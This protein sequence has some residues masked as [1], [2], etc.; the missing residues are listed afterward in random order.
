MSRD[1]YDEI[2]KKFGE[3]IQLE[4]MEPDE[5]GYCCLAFNENII[6]HIQ[7]N[8]PNDSIMLFCEVGVIDEDKRSA[9]RDKM[10]AA[11]L[12]WQGTAGGTLGV[13]DDTGEVMMSFQ[14]ELSGLEFSKFQ[15]VLKEYVKN[16]ELWMNALAA[17]EKGE[18]LTEIDAL[19]H[20]SGG[21]S[22]AATGTDEGQSGGI[23][24]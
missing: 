10:L 3:L 20:G 17:L 13:D 12:M 5:D 24:A 15:E 2:L 8:E 6:V 9:V 19:L 14:L 21:S 22:V 7:Y 18:P 11:D 23:R 4:D 16:C 1:N